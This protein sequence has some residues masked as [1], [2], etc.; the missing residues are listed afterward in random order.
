MQ[1]NPTVTYIDD[2]TALAALGYDTC[3]AISGGNPY[4]LPEGVVRVLVQNTTTYEDDLD[5]QNAGIAD[6]DL[7]VW[8]SSLGGGS[9][10]IKEL[11]AAGIPA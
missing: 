1:L 5:A 2:S 9:N 4:G 10:F 7:Y 11:Y 3:Y 8:D 6:G